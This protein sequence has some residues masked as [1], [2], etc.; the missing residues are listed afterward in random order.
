MP[1]LILS[2][3]KALYIA[4]KASCLVD[5]WLKLSVEVKYQSGLAFWKTQRSLLLNHE[6]IC[7]SR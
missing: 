1:V 7:S 2:V 6:F 3:K 4:E 5:F